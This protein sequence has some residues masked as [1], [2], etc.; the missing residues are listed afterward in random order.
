MEGLSPASYAPSTQSFERPT[1]EHIAPA[2]GG[3]DERHVICSQD[4]LPA[5]ILDAECEDDVGSGFVLPQDMVPPSAFDC[6]HTDEQNLEAHNAVEAEVEANELLLG[7]LDPIAAAEL[8]FYGPLRH[9]LSMVQSMDD[10]SDAATQLGPEQQAVLDAALRGENLFFTGVA[11]TGKSLVLRRIIS[12]LRE[13]FGPAGD[14]ITAG[15]PVAVTALTGI[16]ATNIGGMTLH[17]WGGIG[18]GT[19]IEDLQQAYNRPF[20]WRD[21]QVLLIDEIS[22]MSSKLFQRLEHLAREIRHDER[23][24]GGIQVRSKSAPVARSD[25][26]LF[27]QLILCGDFLQ[28]P[29]VF[30]NRDINV[31]METQMA[32]RKTKLRERQGAIPSTF[33]LLLLLLFVLAPLCFR[34]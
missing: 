7:P 25:F 19:R 33:L 15:D 8:R 11:G 3:A 28:L 9:Q 14:G 23:P 5:T 6:D 22:M 24:F 12:A 17:R 34:T 16:A 21:C 27:V 29:P 10:D 30:S 26:F 4:F 20:T 2:G 18:L 13:K 31:L 32:A 1:P